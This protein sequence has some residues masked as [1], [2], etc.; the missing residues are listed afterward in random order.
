[1]IMPDRG[2][3]KRRTGSLVVPPRQTSQNNHDSGV[4]FGSNRSS[5]FCESDASSVM[6]RGDA[7]SRNGSEVSEQMEKPG[8]RVV[9]NTRLSALTNQIMELVLDNIKMLHIN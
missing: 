8:E 4:S 1:M 2:S 3:S 5:M 6:L 7:S 9:D